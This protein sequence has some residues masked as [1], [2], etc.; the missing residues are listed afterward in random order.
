VNQALEDAVELAQAIQEGGTTQGSL[1]A[2]EASRIPRVQQI[3]AAEMVSLTP[4]CHITGEN[5]LSDAFLGTE[6]AE[7]GGC[8]TPPIYLCTCQ[9]VL[10]LLRQGLFRTSPALHA[11][12]WFTKRQIC[13]VY[14]VQA[15]GLKSYANRPA[16]LPADLAAFKHAKAKW[17]G[18]DNGAYE[19]WIMQKEFSPLKAQEAQ[20]VGGHT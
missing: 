11:I 7:N 19:K 1:R 15:S 18:T 4:G 6:L 8:I 10:P 12:S 2:Y 9:K 20:M 17:E 16:E 13:R 14:A 5:C 3:L